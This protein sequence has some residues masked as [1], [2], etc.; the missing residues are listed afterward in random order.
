MMNYSQYSVSHGLEIGESLFEILWEENPYGFSEDKFEQWVNKQRSF[1][2]WHTH[3]TPLKEMCLPERRWGFFQEAFERDCR[4]QFL[5]SCF[6]AGWFE[7]KKEDGEVA[8]LL[9]EP[10][11]KKPYRLSFYRDNG[12][13]Y[14]EV[15]SDREEALSHLAARGFTHCE[16]AIDA[17][18]GTEK[19]N[20]GLWVTKWIAEGIHP[21]EGAKR[22]AHL[23]DVQH[24]FADVLGENK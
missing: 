5:V 10:S 23:D 24:L 13:T 21:M 12:P 22:D 17:L 15:Y 19:W 11:G 7:A 14:H 9:P 6:P 16:G 1:S 2:R 8:A 4:R 20:R 3:Y 18:V